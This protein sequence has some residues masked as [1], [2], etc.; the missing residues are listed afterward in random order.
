[1]LDATRTSA[2]DLSWIG[3]LILLSGVPIMLS[4]SRPLLFVPGKLV[5]LIMGSD[6]LKTMR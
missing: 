2:I 3:S 6:F 5:V 1:M 4:Y